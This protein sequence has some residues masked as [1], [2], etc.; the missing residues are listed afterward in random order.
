MQ[1][2]TWFRLLFGLANI[3]LYKHIFF[4]RRGT[5]CR[6]FRITLPDGYLDSV[7]S[8]STA[9]GTQPMSTVLSVL[10]MT[11]TNALE[12]NTSVLNHALEL[13]GWP[14]AL[15]ETQ[16]RLVQVFIVLS[17]NLR[18]VARDEERRQQCFI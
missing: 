4:G 5:G 12:R 11:T 7:S 1:Q 2:Q 8:V 15:L 18:R 16:A 14:Q 9:L 3:H 17:P 6:Q 10:P 13:G